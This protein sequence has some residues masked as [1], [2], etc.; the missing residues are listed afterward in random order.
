MPI[1]YAGI[2]GHA[3]LEML[4]DGIIQLCD[5]CH[6]MCRGALLQS[7]LDKLRLEHAGAVVTAVVSSQGRRAEEVNWLG[8]SGKR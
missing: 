6:R 5:G 4:G 1:Y 8:T 3:Q 7:Q 2:K